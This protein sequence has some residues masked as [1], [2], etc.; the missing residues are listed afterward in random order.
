MDES[1]RWERYGAF[2]GIVFVVLVIVT[3]VISGSPPKETDSA[4]KILKYY[5]DNADGIKVASFVGTL[6][7][8]PILLWAG[9]LWARLRR[10][11]NGQPRL[12][13]VAVLGLV[14]AGAVQGVLTAIGATIVLQLNNVG[15]TE[16]KF[17]FVLATTMGA[18]GNI[19][20]AVLV[21]AVSALAFRTHV[22]P[23]WVAWIGVVDGIVLLVACYGAASTSDAIAVLGLIALVIWAIWLIATSVIMIRH[24]D[25]AVAVATPA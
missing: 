8:L 7:T 22:F 2:G 20:I 11:E 23:A 5:R 18:I 4:A 9:S 21:L 17:F 15:P 14:L 10:A 24:T 6:A 19:G 16:A 25:A 12:A 3:I 13:L 1:A